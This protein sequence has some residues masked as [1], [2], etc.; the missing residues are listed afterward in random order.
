MVRS[1]RDELNEIR[2]LLLN[3]ARPGQR[4]AHTLTRRGLRLPGL[5]VKLITVQGRDPPSA[6]K[7]SHHTREGRNGEYRPG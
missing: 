5:T 1:V 7:R 2:H 4:S 3:A 6:G